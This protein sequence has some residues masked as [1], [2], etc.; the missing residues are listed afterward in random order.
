MLDR[1]DTSASTNHTSNTTS[2]RTCETHATLSLQAQPVQVAALRANVSHILATPMC[3][4]NHDYFD[5]DGQI[6]W[7]KPAAVA[8]CQ[9]CNAHQ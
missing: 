4:K 1:V 5:A 3:Q 9:G 8:G 6:L 2:G 7:Q